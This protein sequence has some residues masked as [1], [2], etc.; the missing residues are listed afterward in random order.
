MILQAVARAFDF[1][2]LEAVAVWM[3]TDQIGQAASVV[4]QVQ[5]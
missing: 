2:Q 4:A 3:K 5:Q 1:D